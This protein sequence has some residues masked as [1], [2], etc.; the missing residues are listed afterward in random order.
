M[1]K[2]IVII[3]IILVGIG[4]WYFY[5]GSVNKNLVL[6]DSVVQKFKRYGYKEGVNVCMYKGEKVIYDNQVTT[7]STGQ[8]LYDTN[9]NELGYSASL[10]GTKKESGDIEFSL[11]QNCVYTKFN[12]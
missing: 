3:L 6:S 10:M 8:Y 1:K 12:K 2:I 4:V 5:F 7:D 9:G 11:V